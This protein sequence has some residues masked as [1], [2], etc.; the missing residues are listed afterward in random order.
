MSYILILV[1]INIG[2][3]LLVNSSK[4]LRGW[5]SKRYGYDIIL[6]WWAPVL[7]CILAIL[8]RKNAQ[9]TISQNWRFVPGRDKWRGTI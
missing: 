5:V 4:H 3:I 7:T 1:V 2:V 6:F 8:T 9:K